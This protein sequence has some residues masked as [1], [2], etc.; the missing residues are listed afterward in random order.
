L[1]ICNGIAVVTAVVDYCSLI[2]AIDAITI[3][4]VASTLVTAA[5]FAASVVVT[6]L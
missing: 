6:L 1:V 3:T 2:T 5:L 4:V